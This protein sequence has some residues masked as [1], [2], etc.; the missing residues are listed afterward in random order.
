MAA[1]RGRSA[2]NVPSN[3]S[4]AAG[5]PAG[6]S[7]A[8]GPGAGWLDGELISSGWGQRPGV[9]WRPQRS[10]GPCPGGG[11]GGAPS[12]DVAPSAWSMGARHPPQ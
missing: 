4:G 11:T 2:A 7:L 6:R 5:E 12:G 1:V 3:G 8:R 9:V 10:G